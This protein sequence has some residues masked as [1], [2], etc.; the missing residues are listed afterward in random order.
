MKPR[1]LRLVFFA[2]AFP[3]L[4]GFGREAI[5]ARAEGEISSPLPERC[6]VGD[7]ISLPTTIEVDGRKTSVETNA[8]SP[9][10]EIFSGR[11]FVPDDPGKY[12]IRYQ[13]GHVTYPDVLLV[14]E[15]L[16]SGDSA[17]SSVAL[18][19]YDF[20]GIE[21]RGAYAALTEG[22]G[23]IY[24]KIIDVSSYTRDELLFSANIIA[25]TTGRAD[26]RTLT[27]RLSDVYDGSNS[28]DFVLFQNGDESDI[29]TYMRA[30]VPGDT[31][32]V[33]P[34]GNV[35]TNSY[36][37]WVRCSFHNTPWYGNR[38]ED[39]WK[40]RLD[41]A[42]RKVYTDNAQRENLAVIDLD[43]RQYF[44]NPWK[45]FRDGRCRLSVFASDFVNPNGHIFVNTIGNEDMRGLAD[46]YFIDDVPPMLDVDFGEYAEDDLPIAYPGMRYPVFEANATDLDSPTKPVSVTVTRGSGAS[47]VEYPIRDGSFK[48]NAIGQY[49]I[50]YEVEDYFGNKDDRIVRVRCGVFESPLSI[51]LVG[52]VPSIGLTGHALALPSYEVE[53]ASGK[54][55]VRRVVEIDGEAS[56]LPS[57]EAAYLPTRAG[58]F[59]FVYEAEDYLAQKAKTVFE[60][61]VDVDPNPVFL[62]TPR[63]PRVLLQGYEN[64]LPSLSAI[65]YADEGKRIPAKIYVKEGSEAE[66][67]VESDRFIP[68][69]VGEDQ[70]VT[71]RYEAVGSM[72]SGCVSYAVLSR[73]IGLSSSHSKVDKERLLLPSGGCA[74]DSYR[75]WNAQQFAAYS[76]ET[77]G[78]LSYVNPVP[79]M[80]FQLDFGWGAGEVHAKR[81]LVTLEDDRDG[82]VSLQVA[83]SPSDQGV[84]ISFNG[85][86]AT[87]LPSLS[88]AEKGSASLA[89][90]RLLNSL[91]FQNGELE[92]PVTDTLSGAPFF[93]FPSG[94]IR[95]S[96]SLEGVS[97]ASV[98]IVSRVDGMA[99][100]A[101]NNIPA[102]RVMVDGSYALNASLHDEFA[103]KPLFCFNLVRPAGDV[104]TTVRDPH[105]NIVSSTNGE[106]LESVVI[107][108]SEAISLESYGRYLYSY[109]YEESHSAEDT[110]VTVVDEVAPLISVG[111]LQNAYFL[112]DTLTISASAIDQQDGAVSVSI[113]LET[114]DAR[115]HC[116]LDGR[117]KLDQIGEHRL[118]VSAY[119][120]RGNLGR[121]VKVFGV[122][123]RLRK[124]SSASHVGLAV[125]ISC[126]GILVAAAIAVPL[127]LKK[128]HHAGKGGK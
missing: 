66:R 24:R 35:R 68:K 23:L 33:E 28:I 13:A 20:D 64:P 21:R 115:L 38:A 119:D 121:M 127:A 97:S 72:G 74:F 117:Y 37:A 60:V 22:N 15:P 73:F 95:F 80:N 55:K 104:F 14:C 59:R 41:Y 48:P 50:H 54:A 108:G 122:T 110:L 78:A 47:Q 9:S 61:K 90:D 17:S 98:L 6:F 128:R 105:G 92:L 18:Q 69:I 65:D 19:D 29:T 57:D 49:A 103:I 112:G 106:R 84:L 4:A 96:L 3:F 45:G 25:N 7:S 93:G 79:A 43:D 63:F 89:F 27:V 31:K 10:G 87:L 71:I 113:V 82:S 100:N 94:K 114:P 26:F 42:T 46:N 101:R 44:V 116:L 126:G 39:N 12:E 53:N 40:I 62:E 111:T 77:D 8:V 75:D 30:G 107:R 16:L 91:F 76:F 11:S 83:F 124:P 51:R 56:E 109:T 36:G 5:S 70:E 52:E 58:I 1:S 85:G 118:V 32:G 67:L 99:F 81:L 86:D 125:G 2:V 120:A 102:S 88:F 123:E 34:N